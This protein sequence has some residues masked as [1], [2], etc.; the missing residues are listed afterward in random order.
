MNLDAGQQ[1]MAT[2]PGQTS[3]H[4]FTQWPS[5]LK[6]EPPNGAQSASRKGATTPLTA[7]DSYRPIALYNPAHWPNSPPALPHTNPHHCSIHPQPNLHAHHPS[8][9]IFPGHHSPNG[10]R[11]IAY[12]TTSTMASA[13]T[14]HPA[15]KL[16]CVL[17]ARPGATQSPNAPP[18]PTTRSSSL[19]AA[20]ARPISHTLIIN[21]L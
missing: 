14:V 5:Q 10:T 21:Y 15:P 11:S 7:L 19:S 3:I 12:F 4:S 18:S 9:T 8:W 6:G 13:L 2:T 1:Y 20:Y 16:I 17:T